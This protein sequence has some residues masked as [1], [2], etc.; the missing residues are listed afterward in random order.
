[1]RQFVTIILL[2]FFVGLQAQR[3]QYFILLFKGDVMVKQPGQSYVNAKTLQLISFNDFIQLKNDESEVVIGNTAG[4]HTAITGK[5][6]YKLTDIQ[7]KEGEKGTGA[8]SKFLAFLYEELLHPKKGFNL[9]SIA[10][11]WGGG[12]R[13]TCDYLKSPMNNL[14]SSK[15]SIVFMWQ[16]KSR[17]LDYQ[18]TLYDSG[19]NTIFSCNIRDTQIVI[20]TGPL[21]TSDKAR[22]FWNVNAVT[23]PCSTVPK[24]VFEFLSPEEEEKVAAALIQEVARNENDILYNLAIADKLGRNGFIDKALIYIDKSYQLLKK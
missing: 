17:V 24:N 21:R 4:R 8:T 5:G 11:S 18:F 3:Q 22:Y 15:D 23:N 6:I 10:E 2:F 16:H 9:R 7:K 19:A 12:S 14:H 20:S 13:G 1:M